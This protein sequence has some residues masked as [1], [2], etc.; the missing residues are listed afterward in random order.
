MVLFLIMSILLYKKNI[1]SQ[2]LQFLFSKYPVEKKTTLT[3]TCK[4]QTSRVFCILLE[5]DILYRIL[6][7]FYKI[8]KW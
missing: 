7:N 1:L 6:M 5:S 8:N 2:F 4:L 3:L